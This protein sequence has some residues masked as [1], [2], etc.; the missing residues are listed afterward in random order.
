MSEAMSIA[1]RTVLDDGVDDTT[2]LDE[3]DFDAAGVLPVGGVHPVR[4]TRS[5]R[6]TF[7]AVPT[8]STLGRP[9]TRHACE[10]CDAWGHHNASFLGTRRPS[11]I[12]TLASKYNGYTVFHLTDELGPRIESPVSTPRSPL[13]NTR[14]RGN[15]GAPKLFPEPLHPLLL[16]LLEL[17]HVAHE[18]SHR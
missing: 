8:S 16:G 6:G 14:V 3:L 18:P 13:V 17:H 4:L 12:D 2:I 10:M 5:V 9:S 1:S 15:V 7:L 11:L